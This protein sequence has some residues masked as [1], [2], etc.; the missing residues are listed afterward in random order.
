[1]SLSKRKLERELR[2]L[3]S[4]Q[5]RLSD[6]QDIQMRKIVNI[7]EKDF[8]TE[9]EGVI[10]ESSKKET[11]KAELLRAVWKQDV[12]DRKEFLNDQR[13]NSELPLIYHAK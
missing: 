1:M 11:E 9:L 6:Q 10:G 7:I 4:T 12:K 8:G 5:C 2:K 3:K 13:R